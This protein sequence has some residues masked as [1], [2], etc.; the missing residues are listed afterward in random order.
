MIISKFWDLNLLSLVLQ[1]KYYI[2]VS[3]I[4]LPILE[5]L[6]RWGSLTTGRLVITSNTASAFHP[7][8]VFPVHVVSLDL[9]EPSEAG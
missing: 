3:C 9:L 7:A 1:I 2:Y 8:S 4:E 5:S 6:L